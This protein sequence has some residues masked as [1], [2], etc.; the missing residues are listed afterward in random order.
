MLYLMRDVYNFML[1]PARIAA[2]ATQLACENPF[3]TKAR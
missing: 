2:G 1:L 3:N